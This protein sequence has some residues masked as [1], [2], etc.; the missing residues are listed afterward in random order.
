[1]TESGGLREYRKQLQKAKSEKIYAAAI[2]YFRVNGFHGSLIADIGRAANVSTATLY[3]YFQ[4]KELLF[5]ACIERVQ[6]DGRSEHAEN[7]FLDN[8]ARKDL[9][10]IKLPKGYLAARRAISKY[11]ES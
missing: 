8:V 1:L 5:A 4:S 2:E 7:D 10:A 3:K 9:A 6:S 11:V